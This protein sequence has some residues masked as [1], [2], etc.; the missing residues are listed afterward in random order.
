VIQSEPDISYVHV[1]TSEGRYLVRGR[2]LDGQTRYPTALVDD[3][4]VLSV[5]RSG[6]A[7]FRYD[8]NLLEATTS[9]LV[10]DDVF[11][12]LQ[13]GFSGDALSAEIRGMVQL[14]LSQGLVLIALGVI[15]A[16]IIARYITRPLQNLAGAAAKIGQGELDSPV[17]VGGAREVSILAEALDKMRTELQ[18]LYNGLELKV[19]ERT[20]DLEKAY[21]ELKTLDIMKDE[22][23]STVSHELRTPLT[24]IK[25][26]AEILLKYRDEDP[27]IQ[28][29]FLEIIDVECDRLTRL[30]NDLLDLVRMES[31]EMEWEFTRVDLTEII[32]TSVNGIQALALQK[33]I[34]LEI[35]EVN[36]LPRLES[37]A[38]KLVQVI[39][40]LLSNS[41]KFTP[42][43]G[44]I[45]VRSRLLPNSDP[46]AG[47]PM[48]EVAISDTGVG[49]STT[50]IDKIFDRFQQV[51]QSVN[52]RPQGTGLG[53]S[54]SKGIVEQLGGKI[55]VE[56]EI[57]EGRTFY[58]T[59]PVSSRESIG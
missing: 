48:A 26:A 18:S 34:S 41:I 45:R 39:M 7:D 40:N 19:L 53:L 46:K 38:D 52:D 47:V 11:G 21:R 50:D 31:G 54:I 58:F 32:A 13:L 43:G 23:I 1:A 2:E 56:I 10:D 29:E 51:G 55:W 36:G 9:I 37:D 8:G 4:F 25:S 59:V 15:A 42:S 35:S 30:I 17:P 24:S 28:S 12:A 44:L 5:A 33:D 6:Q 49:F 57:C 14:H 3:E 20:E 16:Y 22:F 27:D